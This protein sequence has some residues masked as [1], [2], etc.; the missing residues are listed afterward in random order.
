MKKPTPIDWNE[1]GFTICRGAAGGLIILA[2]IGL[3]AIGQFQM[4]IGGVIQLAIACSIL[5]HTYR[6]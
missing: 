4:A 5:A 6:R 2:V 1:F 3:V